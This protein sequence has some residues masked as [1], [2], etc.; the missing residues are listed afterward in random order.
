MQLEEI[1]KVVRA[2]LPEAVIVAGDLNAKSASWG[3]PRTDRRGKLFEEWTAGFD[4]TV[5]NVGSVN[6]CVRPQGVSIVDITLASRA[7]ARRI[8]RWRVAA[9]LETL[10]D[11]RYIEL[12]YFTTLRGQMGV[13]RI[14]DQCRWFV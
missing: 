5:V 10:S 9:K 8:H 7:A 11:H 2:Y 4:L 12:R 3:C 1:G 6:T 13:Q 14:T